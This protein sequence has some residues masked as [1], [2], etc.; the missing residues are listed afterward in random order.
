MNTGNITR[1][2][3]IAIVGLAA[4]EKVEALNCE[5]TNRVGFNGGCQG[6]SLTEYSAT[7]S[8]E[9]TDG[10]SCNLTAYYYLKKDQEDK[11]A[12]AEG[13]GSAIDWVIDHYSI[14]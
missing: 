3:A 10:D 1:E 2:Q 13:D 7:V 4:V 14:L 6:N 9:D 11:L 5:P 12:E 8:A